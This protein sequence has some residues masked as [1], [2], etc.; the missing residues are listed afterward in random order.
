V[1]PFDLPTP[2]VTCEVPY[3]AAD[4]AADGSEHS[5]NRWLRLD[6]GGS[7]VLVAS[8]RSTRPSARAAA[9]RASAGKLSIGL[10]NNGQYGFAVTPDGSVG[11][12]LARGAVHTRFGDQ[13][14][15]PNESHTFI[16]QGQVDTRFRLIAGTTGEVTD[17][18]IPTALELNQPLDLFAVFY[19]LAPQLDPEAASQPFL[20]V[21][22]QTVQLGALKKA[23]DE[24]AL[25]VRLFESVGKPT[26]A[27]LSIEGAGDDYQLNLNPFEIVTLKV[28]RGK[29]GAGVTIKP[30]GLVE[31]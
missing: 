12:S 18:L 10:A 13:P 9:K 2:V 8:T 26:T 27:V 22:P 24:D 7:A 29:K 3:G 5:Q 4:R 6:E 14:I 17:A 20:R 1:F 28:K 25:I 23:E 21:T 15:E 16:D 11:L 30:T 31:K 19:P